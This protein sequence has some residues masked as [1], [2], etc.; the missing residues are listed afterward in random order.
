MTPAE[1]CQRAEEV[2]EERTLED[3][4]LIDLRLY[5]ALVRRQN[6]VGPLDE[7]YLEYVGKRYPG[8]LVKH[9]DMPKVRERLVRKKKDNRQGLLF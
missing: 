2:K 1:F 6:F 7:F 4:Q 9:R 3:W 8:Y 5:C